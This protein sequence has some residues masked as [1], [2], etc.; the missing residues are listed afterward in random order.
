LT[1]DSIRGY[2]PLADRP[3]DRNLSMDYIMQTGPATKLLKILWDSPDKNCAGREEE[4][5]GD[6]LPTD[7][8]AQ[9]MCVGC[10]QMQT[11]SEY[12]D[13]A[14]PSWGVWGGKVQGRKLEEA[15]RD[16]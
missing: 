11:C 7:A 14:H 8:E 12:R 1:H 13:E 4:F 3:K 2:R 9:L 10:P 5:S 15:M 6:E 16:E